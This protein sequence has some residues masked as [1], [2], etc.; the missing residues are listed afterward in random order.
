QDWSQAQAQATVTEGQTT[1]VRIELAAPL[2]VT[3]VVRDAAGVPVAGAIVGVFPNYG[4]DNADTMTDANG[5]YEVG[6]QKPHWVGS[7]NQSYYLLARHAERKLAALQPMEETT[8]T[9]DLTLKP[10][11]SVSGRVQDTNGKAVTN[12]MAYV[13]L[14][15]EN[16]GFTVTRQ[17][18]V[19]DEQGRIHMEALPS[20]ERYGLSVSGRNYGS[21]Q[22]EMDAAVPKADHYDFPPLVVRLADRK[23]AGRVLGT[24]GAPAVGAQIWMNG[25]GQPS[26]NAITDADGRFAFD[27]VCEGAVQVSANLKGLNGSAEAMGG[28]TNVVI[29]FESGNRY[30]AEASQQTLTG[31]V[32]DPAARP[33]VGVRVVV[34]PTWGQIDVAQTD[35]NGEFSV[36]WQAQPGMRDAKYFAIARDVERNLAAIE[37]VVTNKT[38]ITLRLEAGFSISGTVQDA[39]GAPLSRANI[40]LNIMLGN[41]GGMVEYQGIKMNADGTFT[42]PA[43]PPGRQYMV[44]ATANGYGSARKNIGKNQSRTNSLQLS[45]FKLK[46]ADR[47]L[48]GQVFNTDGK[49]LSGAQISINGEGQPNGNMRTDADGH[50]KF[51]VCAGPVQIYAWSQSGSGGYN[52]ASS[53]ARGGDASVVVKMGVQQRQNPVTQRETPLKPQPWTATALVAWPANHKAVAIILLVL[54]GVVLWGTV[55]GIFWSTRKRGRRAG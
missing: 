52:S 28:D 55:G 16:M 14:H 46:T 24:N 11:M 42:I 50:F 32:Y 22:Q 47:L 37:P 36:G 31:T 7:G 45:P 1:Q 33:A 41:M 6:W 27:A 23:L 2:K 25:E 4:P 40:N 17:P 18:L 13:M 35:T 44:Y 3:G 38:S 9:L 29:R 43:L 12:V 5:H 34:T 26:G 53:Q 8:T 51:K 30:Y 39:Q 54:Q 49:P 10:A 21:A 19:P 15:T 20:G 48:A